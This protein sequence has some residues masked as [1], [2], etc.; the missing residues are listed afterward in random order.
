MLPSVVKNK[1]DE[2]LWDLAKAQADAQGRAIS[3][4]QAQNYAFVAAKFKQLNPDRFKAAGVLV[5]D[6]L[7]TASR[8][9]L[10]AREIVAIVLEASGWVPAELRG[11]RDPLTLTP[12]LLERSQSSL[13]NDGSQVPPARDD[14]GHELNDAG[15]E[16]ESIER[17]AEALDASMNDSLV[18]AATRLS[19]GPGTVEVSATAT[20]RAMRRLAKR[21][22]GD[23]S[24]A[25]IAAGAYAKEWGKTMYA[26]ESNS[27][28]RTVW[29]T[30]DKAS[31]Y[32]SYISNTGPIVYSVEP[33][34]TVRAHEVRR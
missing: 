9:P 4:G 17:V 18:T 8:H 32:L 30:T 2:E 25:I 26:Y 12:G 1:R 13:L 21:S 7:R 15:D 27:Y 31:M 10:H 19:L 29:Q 28:M 6:L 5:N 16:I 3:E 20:L 23:R 11:L 33:D 22:Q 24:G 14:D 34:L